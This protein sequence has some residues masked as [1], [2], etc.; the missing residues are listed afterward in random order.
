MYVCGLFSSQVRGRGMV[1]VI[2][3]NRVAVLL[4][5]GYGSDESFLLWCDLSGCRPFDLNINSVF[6]S[7]TAG[8]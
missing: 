5:L 2:C 1:Y 4:M 3:C 8:E 7:F 6:C